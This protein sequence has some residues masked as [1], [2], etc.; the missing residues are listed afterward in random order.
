MPRK[1]RDPMEEKITLL[2]NKAPMTYRLFLLYAKIYKIREKY[3][4]LGN[5]RLDRG[6][7]H[8]EQLLIELSEFNIDN[9]HDV[10]GYPDNEGER[11]DGATRLRDDL[12]NHTDYFDVDEMGYITIK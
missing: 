2:L 5:V 3:G 4:V 7:V 9:L 11:F 10:L 12:V 1:T 6:K 8:D